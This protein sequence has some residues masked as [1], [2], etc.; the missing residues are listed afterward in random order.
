M[1]ETR[2]YHSLRLDIVRA[3]DT[4]KICYVLLPEGLEADGTKWI[5]RASDKFGTSIVIMSRMDWND[6]LTPWEAAGV[7]KKEKPFG[8]HASRFLR[9]LGDD[10]FK[11]LES[12][13]KIKN[14]ERTLVGVSLSGLFGLWAACRCDLFS[15]IASISGSLWY[16]GFVDWMKGSEVNPAV[17]HIFISIGSREG[18]AKDRRMSTVIADTK[19]IAENLQ[20]RGIRVTYI[21]EAGVSHFSPIIPRLDKALE[22]LSVP[23]EQPSDGNVS[24]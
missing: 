22:A 3:K 16:D 13:M 20:S 24:E 17:Q 12:D 2:F 14:A 4:D 21:T 18:G 19:E 5:E 8:G 1:L 11:Q 23:A 7:M 6:Q 9:T 15:S 10:Y